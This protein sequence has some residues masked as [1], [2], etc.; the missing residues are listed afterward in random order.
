MKKDFFLE[1]SVLDDLAKDFDL[2]EMPLSGKVFKFVGLSIFF[3]IFGVIVRL[4]FIGAWENDFYRDRALVNAGQIVKIS[5]ERGI[6]YDR[7]GETLVRN[8]PVIRAR[9]KIPELLKLSEQD[10]Q[11]TIKSISKIIEVPEKEIDR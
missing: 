6:I 4:F 8:L 3:I 10:R 11:L 9:L 2:L 7:F 5:T 1:E